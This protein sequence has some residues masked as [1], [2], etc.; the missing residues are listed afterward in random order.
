MTSR[1]L[2]RVQA[3]TQNRKQFGANV[4]ATM[5]L[6]GVL[7]L[8]SGC[9]GATVANPTSGGGGGGGQTQTYAISGTL[10]P[11]AAA[12]GTTIILGGASSATTTP[13]GSGAY[14]FAGLVNGSYTVTPTNGS[15]TFSPASLNVAVSGANAASENFTG[16][17]K[18][19]PTFAISGTVSP[20]AAASGTTVTLG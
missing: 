9:V 14:S 16:T 19:T 5:V 12:S 20:T 4:I 18:T 15:Y 10:S 1:L 13:N 2:A 11:T 3:K 8:L 17:A 6:P 7:A